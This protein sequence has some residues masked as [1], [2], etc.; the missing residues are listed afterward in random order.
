MEP[1]IIRLALATPVIPGPRLTLDAVLAAA[2]YRET[3]DLSAAHDDLPLARSDGVPQASQAFIE[4]PARWLPIQASRRLQTTG[5]IA[6]GPRTPA[7]RRASGPYRNRVTDYVAA[8]TPAVWW[9]AH[10]DRAEI[11]ATLN[12][13]MGVGTKATHG[14]GEIKGWDVWPA[15]ADHPGWLDTEGTPLRPV[16]VHSW[17][18]AGLS[19]DTRVID[20]E[21]WRPP[22]WR[23]DDA[24]PC[25][26]PPAEDPQDPRRL[27][28]RLGD[29]NG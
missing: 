13:L 19:L 1:L 29:C 6:V 16:P 24:I 21:T 2:L 28:A 10:G 14:W 9:Q 23:R 18:A 17:T 4:E 5:P 11:E 25:V 7:I 8:A 27:F 22:Y 26:V 12:S 15:R 20:V 3:G